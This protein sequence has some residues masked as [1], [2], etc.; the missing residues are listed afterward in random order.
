MQIK[1]QLIEGVHILFLK[2]RMDA[3]S[4]KELKIKIQQIIKTNEPRVVI[5]LGEID[6]IDSSGL[7]TLVAGYRLV[8]QEGG[9][10]RLAS[11]T[12]QT[13]SLLELTRMDK[14]FDIFDHH[15]KAFESFDTDGEESS[16]QI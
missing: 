13:Q 16:G 6:F 10:V 3:S 9:D 15:L 12:P 1:S 8:S 14:L 4:A 5:D 2:G 11:P 7:G